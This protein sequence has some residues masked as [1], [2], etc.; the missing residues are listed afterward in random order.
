MS[1]FNIYQSKKTVANSSIN[2]SLRQRKFKDPQLIRNK[3]L[4]QYDLY[5]DMMKNDP[6]MIKL[7]NQRESLSRQCRNVLYQ[8]Q[9]SAKTDESDAK[10]RALHD[11]MSRLDQQHVEAN[12]EFQNYVETKLKWLKTNFEGIYTMFTDTEKPPDRQTLDHVLNAF[13]QS[14]SGQ[15]TKKEA[16]EAGIKFTKDKFQLPEDFFDMSKIN[17]LL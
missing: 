5:V 8:L 2:D 13:C 16:M 11:S 14:E 7:L 3:I 17:Q 15:I 10:V 1:Q 9:E 4:E 12:V 6:T